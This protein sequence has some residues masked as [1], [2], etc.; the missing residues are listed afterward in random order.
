MF[1]SRIPRVVVLTGLVLLFLLVGTNYYFY[2]K[3][4][5]PPST[6][7]DAP[8][9]VVENGHVA[10]PPRP[11]GQTIADEI[12]VA[13]PPPPPKPPAKEEGQHPAAP[14][15]APPPAVEP[16]IVEEPR[17]PKGECLP[18]LRYLK[19]VAAT[20]QLGP[21]VKFTRRCIQP[22]FAPDVNR[23]DVANVS[24]PLGGD[25]MTVDVAE[26]ADVELPKCVPIKLTVP[27]PRPKAKFPHLSFGIA[28]DYDRLVDPS[29]VEPFAHWLSGSEAKLV[30]LVNDLHE[31]SRA[32][33]YNLKKLYDDAQI[34][35]TFVGPISADIKPTQSHFTVLRDMINTANPETQWYG[36]LD[37]DTFFPSLNALDETLGQYDPKDELYIGTLSEDFEAVRNFGYMAFG[38][39]GAFLSAPLA[40]KLDANMQLCLGEVAG[41]QGDTLI[42]D[43]VYRHSKAKLTLVKDLYQ[44]DLMG[45]PSGF[46]ES[47]VRPLNLHHWKSWF[48]LP[49]VKMATASDFCGDC[50]LQRWRFGND[51]VFSNGYSIAK[52]RDG[53]MGLDLD[54]VEGTFSN[55]SPGFYFSIGP[56]RDKLS[57]EA[58]KSYLFED[59]QTD[60]KGTLRQLYVWR[61]NATLNE[62]DEVIE[63]VWQK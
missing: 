16:I 2:E 55:L 13:P 8:P 1:P 52:Y 50:F 45:D 32:D 19:D 35:A 63:L 10:A 49:V 38:G 59:A 61:G 48:H 20:L 12:L 22:V 7:A 26:C 5:Q 53:L 43:C 9:N 42:R 29:T 54:A 31:K 15:A 27:I 40:R 60:E 14:P 11:D 44:Q 24:K 51:T 25:A 58:K 39:A 37:D 62:M 23:N 36:L 46:F 6:W 4:Y 57:E 33:M 47:G 17:P 56:F 18:A 41:D 28:T 3:P 34:D 30:A 21:S